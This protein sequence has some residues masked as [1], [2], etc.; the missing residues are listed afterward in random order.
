MA[1]AERWFNEGKVA[2]EGPTA[3]IADCPYDEGAER[4]WWTRGFAYVSRLRRAYELEVALAESKPKRCN[5]PDSK[6]K[7]VDV[8]FQVWWCREC[9]AIRTPSAVTST[10]HRWMRPRR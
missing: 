6:A 10:R 7:L 1:H 9:G 2:A 4:H 5:H 8:R 3:G